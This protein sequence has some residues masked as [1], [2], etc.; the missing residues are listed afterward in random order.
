MI[1]ALISSFEI[2]NVSTSDLNTFLWIAAFVAD[3]ASVNPNY[4]KMILANDLSTFP[5]KSN[6]VF[7]NG[8]KSIPKIFLIVLFYAIGFLKILY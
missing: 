4:I 6:S 5:I 2:I 8:P 3:A 1:K 7:S